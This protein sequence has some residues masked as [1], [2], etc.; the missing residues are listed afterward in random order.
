[1][2]VFIGLTIVAI[3][4]LYV[5]LKWH[6][7]RSIT[8]PPGEEPH[9]VFGNLIQTG[10]LSGKKAPHEMLIDYQRRYGDKFMLWF[11]HHRCVVFCL[12]EHAQTI[13]SDRHTFEQSQLILPNCDLLCPHGLFLLTGLKWK[14]HIR[15]MLTMFKGAKITHYLKTIVECTDRLIDQHLHHNQVHKDLKMHCQS[16]FANIMG[17]IAFNCDFNSA[18]NVPLKNALEDFNFQLS[19][20]A[21]L[22]WVP[23]CL[24]KL[25]LK[26]N[27][28]YQRSRELVR[29]LTEQI[30]QNELDNLHTMEDRQSK[31]PIVAFASSLNEQADDKKISSGLTRAEILDEMLTLAIAGYESTATALAWFIF[32]M[33]KYPHV[34]ERMKK[35]LREHQLLITSDSECLPLLTQDILDSLTYCECVTKEVC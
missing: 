27:W 20:L 29:Q 3:T 25:Y 15:V 24:L 13:F 17:F 2:L 12:R 11:G 33:S 34:Q 35:E 26:F 14:R 8:D 19:L 32:Y 21:V 31:T 16:L 5:Y 23:R 9:I 4:L 28:K 10:L 7:S 1:M 30:L 22:P 18:L 6:Y